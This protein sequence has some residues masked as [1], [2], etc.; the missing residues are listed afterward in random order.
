MVHAPTSSWRRPRA[1]HFGKDVPWVC[2]D[3]ACV[4]ANAG[5]KGWRTRGT[6]GF[7]ARLLVDTLER[8]T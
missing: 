4:A 2:I 7:G 3:I 1:G 5:P 8:I 6:S